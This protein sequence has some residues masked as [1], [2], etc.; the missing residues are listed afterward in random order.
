MLE[1][2]L[3]ELSNHSQGPDSLSH[4][5]LC[6]PSEMTGPSDGFF[7]QAVET[8]KGP[9]AVSLNK[10]EREKQIPYANAHVWNLKKRY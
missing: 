1:G 8:D 7:F 9:H 6:S 10:S 2:P 4:S 3:G 5:G